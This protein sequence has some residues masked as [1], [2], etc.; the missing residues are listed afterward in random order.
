MANKD[1]APELNSKPQSRPLLLSTAIA[2]AWAV[3]CWGPANAQSVVG[4]GNLD[5]VVSSVQSPNWSVGGDLVVGDTALGTLVIDAGGTVGNVNDAYFG[6]HDQGMVTVQGG[7][8]GG[9]ASGLTISGQTQIGVESGSNGTL[10]VLGGGVATSTSN[11]AIGRDN[12]STG[13]AL[14][15]GPGSIWTNSS[16]AA[17]VIGAGGSGTLDIDNGGAVHSGQ[18]SIGLDAGGDGHVTVTGAGSL[19][20]PVG[21]IY[22]GAAG[23]GELHVRDGAAVSTAGP[24]ALHPSA[25]IYIGYANGGAG[26]VTISSGTADTSTLS[27]TDF[28]AVGW[29][30]AGTLNIQKGGLVEAGS[31]VRIAA[32]STAQGT[33]NLTGDSTGRGILETGAVIKGDGTGPLVLNLDGG[34]LRANRDQPDFLKGFTTL[35]VNTGGAWFDTNAHDI[36]IGTAFSGTSSLNKLGAGTLTLTGDSSAFSGSTEVQAG[37]LRVDGILGGPA[38]VWAGARLTG[39]GQVGSTANRGTIAPGPPGGFGTLTIAGDY[40]GQGGNL[41]IR[42]ALGDDASPTDRLVITGATSGITPVTVMNVGG[43]GAQTRQG[44]QV[45]QVNGISAGQFDLANGDYVIAGKPALVAGAYGYV[46][47]K[48]QGNGNW[49]LRSSL[50]AVDTSVSAGGDAPTDEGAVAP[51]GGSGPMLYQPGVPVY[52]AYANTLMSLSQLPTL[53]QRVGNRQYDPADTGRNGVWARV[54]GTTAH[55]KPALSTTGEH[56][57]IDSWKAQFGVDRILAGEQGDSRLVGGFTVHYGTAD[58]DVSSVYGNGS[59]D[60]RAYGLGPTLTWYG[61]DGTY[62][63]AQAQATW[64]DSD[65]RSGLAGKLKD[66]NNAHSYGLSIEA[67]KSFAVREGF[68]IIPQAQLSYVSTDFNRFDDQFGARVDSDKGDSLLGRIGVALDYKRSLDDGGGKPRQASVYGVINIKH[69]FLDGTR[70]QVSGVP[71]DSRLGRTWGGVGV[72]GNYSWGGRY[73]L[74]G[75]LGTDADFSGSYAVTASAGFRMTF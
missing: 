3:D 37:T 1:T 22:V 26:T 38:N 62:V 66:G 12:G 48:D 17:F 49:Y 19:W 41:E 44:I 43:S 65:L 42:T 7:N 34:I 21:N 55:L 9:L 29:D 67:G 10:N 20:D 63:D 52:E 59:I 72:G 31:N 28:I 60:T 8:G 58:T 64:F 35:S 69:E 56:Q 33:L 57:N 27:A 54:E 47:Q 2:L 70:V 75:E 46:L 71:V 25:A 11:V 15:S 51:N 4:S 18:G 6:N 53:R 5:P 68:A 32:G 13:M 14:V 45:V 36:G 30:G 74:Y 23:T 40:A 73:A 39:I 16:G 24:D 50:K 61:K